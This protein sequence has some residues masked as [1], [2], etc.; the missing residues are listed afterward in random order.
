[1]TLPLN[2]TFSQSWWRKAVCF[3]HKRKHLLNDKKD[4][5]SNSEQRQWTLYNKEDEHLWWIFLISEF[6]IYL[7]W[8]TLVFLYQSTRQKLQSKGCDSCAHWYIQP[9]IQSRAD[10]I[11]SC[12]PTLSLA[13]N[14]TSP[15]LPCQELLPSAVPKMSHMQKPFINPKLIIYRRFLRQGSILPQFCCPYSFVHLISKILLPTLAS[16]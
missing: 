9:N 12:F 15:P 4:I 1:M 7:H 16:A 14:I 13:H 3:E 2:A 8:N 10:P 11:I 5:Q 6:E